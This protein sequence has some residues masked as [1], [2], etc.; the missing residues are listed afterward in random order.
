M[1]SHKISDL[2]QAESKDKFENLKSNLILEKIFANLPNRQL[3]KI[4]KKNKK[5][6]KRINIDINDYKNYSETNTPTEIE[7]KLAKINMGNL[8]IIMIKISH[9]FIY[10]LIITKK[11][12][13]EI[14]LM[15]MIML[16]LLK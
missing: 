7:K 12:L 8:L 15:K 1:N 11:K 2:K 14:I 6:K 5:I 9:I 13:K 10:I 16:N 4:I 3:L